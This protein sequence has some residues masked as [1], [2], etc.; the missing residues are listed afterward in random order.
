MPKKFKIVIESTGNLTKSDSG[1]WRMGKVSEKHGHTLTI[2][3]KDDVDHLLQFVNFTH[4]ETGDRPGKPYYGPSQFFLTKKGTEGDTI[5]EEVEPKDIG[6]Y[7][8]FVFWTKLDDK[9]PS[10]DPEIIVDPP[11][12]ILKRKTKSAKKTK[13]AKKAKQAR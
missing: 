12:A 8:S 4:D 6:F 10:D 5:T 7:K 2:V 9:S 1:K 13:K 11:S 3:N